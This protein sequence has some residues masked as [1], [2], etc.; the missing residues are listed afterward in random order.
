MQCTGAEFVLEYRVDVL[1]FPTSYSDR[2]RQ[3]YL[4]I[5]TD[6]RS[7]MKVP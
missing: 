2:L 1:D 7:I 3:E 5:P 6:K 4:Y